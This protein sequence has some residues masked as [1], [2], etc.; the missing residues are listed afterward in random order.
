MT[1][2]YTRPEPRQPRIREDIQIDDL[3]DETSANIAGKF[4]DAIDDELA[5]TN[6]PK[7][8]GAT[9]E[10]LPY[11]LIG[12]DLYIAGI[13]SGTINQ[14]YVEQRVV[15]LMTK[16]QAGFSDY[17]VTCHVIE[18][19]ERVRAYSMKDTLSYDDM[20]CLGKVAVSRFALN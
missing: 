3:D 4:V 9:Y 14:T 17:T 6:Q 19:A 12:N 16:E 15:F 18:D 1:A 7:V 20:Y 13:R 10:I 5:I 11:F 2:E 8:T